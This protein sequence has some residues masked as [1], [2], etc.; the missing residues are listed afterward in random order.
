M[1]REEF[2]LRLLNGFGFCI[3]SSLIHSAFLVLEE[4]NPE[5]WKSLGIYLRATCPG[6]CLPSSLGCRGRRARTEVGDSAV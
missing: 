3:F 4:E 2:M 1:N 5:S 6:L